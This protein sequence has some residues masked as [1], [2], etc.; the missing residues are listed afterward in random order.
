MFELL[1]FDSTLYEKLPLTFLYNIR[2]IFFKRF[3]FCCY[4]IVPDMGF[5]VLNIIFCIKIYVFGIH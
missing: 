2:K 3:L 4:V 5:Q 1:R